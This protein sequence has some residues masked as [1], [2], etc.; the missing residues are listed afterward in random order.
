[1]KIFEEDMDWQVIPHAIAWMLRDEDDMLGQ[2]LFY[3]MLRC[4]PSLLS[5]SEK[6]KK[7]ASGIKRKLVVE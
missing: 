3:W 2:T 7:V 6:N 4:F 1:M 5:S